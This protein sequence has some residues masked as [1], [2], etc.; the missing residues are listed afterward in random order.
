MRWGDI[1]TTNTLATQP[2]LISVKIIVFI[3]FHHGW[4]ALMDYQHGCA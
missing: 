2:L 4:P 1:S 3:I